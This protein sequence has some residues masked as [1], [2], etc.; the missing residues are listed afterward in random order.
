MKTITRALILFLLMTVITGVAYPLAVTGLA[1]AIFPRRANGSIIYRDGQAV[2]SELIGQ[3][4]AGPGYFHSRPSAAGQSGYDAGS[5]SGSNLG[6]TNQAFIKNAAQRAAAVR[7]RNDLTK[8]K[9]VASD[10]ITA[11]GSGLDPHITPQ[12]AGLQ[13]SRVAKARHLSEERVQEMVGRNT[14]G[15]QLGLLGEP[16][17]NVL[18]LNI[19][20]DSL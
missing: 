15:R 12:A 1:Q 4:F 6:P 3:N 10:L 20:L 9:P 11:S 8:N 2:G 18:R 13:V 19:M 7:D 16:R 17:V 5:S 14:E